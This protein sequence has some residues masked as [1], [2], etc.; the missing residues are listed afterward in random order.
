MLMETTQVSSN[1]SSTDM[2]SLAD[3]LSFDGAFPITFDLTGS[4]DLTVSRETT[5]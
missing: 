2:S 3:F 5:P 4:D 1:L